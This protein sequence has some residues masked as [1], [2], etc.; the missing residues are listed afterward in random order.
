MQCAACDSQERQRFVR[1]GPILVC[2]T[3]ITVMLAAAALALFALHRR[4]NV[5]CGTGAVISEWNKKRN[6]H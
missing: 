1:R 4:I 3:Y 5:T 2:I 6:R